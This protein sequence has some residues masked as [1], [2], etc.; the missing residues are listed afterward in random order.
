MPEIASRLPNSDNYWD[1]E[2]QEAF[3]ILAER[4]LGSARKAA[5]AMTGD[6]RDQALEGVAQVW[7]K[8]DFNAATAWAGSL[9]QG[10]ERDE[11][12]RA[13]LV[14]QAAVDPSA[15]LDSVHLVPPGGRYAH[16]GTT[17]GARV[18]AEA[19]QTDFEATAVWVAAHPGALG[20]MI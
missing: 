19:A 15:A 20:R 13:A 12:I 10:A 16:F 11:I 18:L 9:A 5:E 6:S 8:S 17:T 2:V 1:R 3:G 4:D 7:G 14:G